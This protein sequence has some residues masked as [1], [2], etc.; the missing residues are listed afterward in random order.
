MFHMFSSFPFPFWDTRNSVWS[1]KVQ[2]HTCQILHQKKGVNTHLRFG[3]FL[4]LAASSSSAL[5]LHTNHI[6]NT[7]CMAN[8]KYSFCMGKTR[9]PVCEWCLTD[10]TPP[11]GKRKQKVPQK[12][13]KTGNIAEKSH[14]S[15]AFNFI[16]IDSHCPLH[17]AL[18]LNWIFARMLVR[19]LSPI[20]AMCMM[21]F[22]TTHSYT[23]VND[24]SVGVLRTMMTA[25]WV[26]A[27]GE[28]LIVRIL[29]RSPH[30]LS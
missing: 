16:W 12:T 11:L 22:N 8:R 10:D 4:S 3:P 7:D 21:L 27:G 15:S 26:W 24:D 30:L 9:I 29:L 19:F 18:F 25:W 2:T 20:W 5:C 1:T 13:D 28:T 17:S 6:L 14:S 23:F